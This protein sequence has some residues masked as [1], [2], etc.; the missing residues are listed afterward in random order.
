MTRFYIVSS[1]EGFVRARG[2]KPNL[3]IC[4]TRRIRHCKMLSTMRPREGI[5]KYVLV[6][7]GRI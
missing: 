1:I 3:D 7:S 4:G 2:N 6:G 5:A